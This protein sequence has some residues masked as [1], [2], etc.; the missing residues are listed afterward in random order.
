M[1]QA[2]QLSPAKLKIRTIVQEIKREYERISGKK[3]TYPL[4]EPARLFKTLFGLEVIYDEQGVLNR[5][6]GGEHLL[7]CL[8]PDGEISPWG[9]DKLVVVNV[10]PLRWK[11]LADVG[12]NPLAHSTA[13]TEAHEGMHYV[14]HYLRGINGIQYRKPTYCRSKDRFRANDFPEWQCD[15]GGGELLMPQEEVVAVLDGKQPGEYVVV[16]PYVAGFKGRFDANQGQMEAR[17]CALGYKLIG[18]KNDWADSLKS[19][20]DRQARREEAQQ[21]AKEQEEFQAKTQ[22]A[23]E[24]LATQ[25]TMWRAQ[26]AIRRLDSLRKNPNAPPGREG[27]FGDIPDFFGNLEGMRD[28]FGGSDEVFKNA[29]PFGAFRRPPKKPK[30]SP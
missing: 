16:E 15:F 28:V 22:A 9:R 12:F 19:D 5:I 13:H 18:P 17:L 30:D 14:C 3:I 25:A 6:A 4:K 11:T 27:L 20:Q 24:S 1:Q 7:G 10:T 29:D 2:I 8:F 23:M 21:R 26:E